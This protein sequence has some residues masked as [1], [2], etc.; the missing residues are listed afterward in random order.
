MLEIYIHIPFCRA[1]CGYCDFNSFPSEENQTEEY[2]KRLIREINES[3]YRG[4]AADTVFIGGGTPSLISPH[5]IEEILNAAEKAFPFKA[6]CEI[7]MEANPESLTPVGL[8]T[9]KQAGINRISMG[10][11]SFNDSELRLLGRIHSSAQA[12]EAYNMIRESGFENINLD[13]MFSYPSQ[14]LESWEESLN[15]AVC[16]NPEHISAYSLIIE[17]NT[18]FYKKY[19]NYQTNEDLDRIMYRKAKEILE[20]AGYIRYEFSNFARPGRECRHNIGYWKRYNYLG[21]GLSSHSFYNNVRFSNTGSFKEYLTGERENYREVLTEGDIMGEYMFLWLRLKEGISFSD[22]YNT[23]GKDIFSVFGGV[24]KKYEKYGFL[25]YDK[26]RLWLT[27][28]GIDVSNTI[29]T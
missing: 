24:I 23:F 10:V 19:K 17:E 4:E 16:L 22:F 5:Y 2:V 26:K 11:Q 25:A 18:L 28:K 12:A 13:L 6:D 7:T 9:Y 1:K 21:F 27:E 8:K 15:T 14:T 3:P 29:F 20:N